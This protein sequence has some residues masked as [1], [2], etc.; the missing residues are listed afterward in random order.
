MVKPQK[1]CTSPAE[2]TT[3]EKELKLRG[4]MREMKSV[5]VA[6][7]GGV[8]SAYLAL[9]ASEELG[10]KALCMLGVSPSVSQVQREEAAKIARQFDLNFQIIQTDELDNPD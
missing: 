9:I 8:D 7:S 1:I 5:L 4:M 10:E 2:L 6:Y 3:A